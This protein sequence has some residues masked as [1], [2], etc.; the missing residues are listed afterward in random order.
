MS[1]FYVD[2][3]P[4]KNGEH[5]PESRSHVSNSEDGIP[6][7]NVQIEKFRKPLELPVRPNSLDLTNTKNA[8]YETVEFDKGNI[9]QSA[10]DIG[11]YDDNVDALRVRECPE[12]GRNLDGTKSNYRI[13]ENSPIAKHIQQER[14]SIAV[15]Y[16]RVY[17]DV[18]LK[19]KENSVMPRKGF[20]SLA[21]EKKVKGKSTS[22]VDETIGQFHG[23]DFDEDTEVFQRKPSQKILSSPTKDGKGFESISL[24]DE[25]ITTPLDEVE[26]RPYMNLGFHK[27][28]GKT[29]GGKRISADD[30]A[31]KMLMNLQS[32][33]KIGDELSA[34]RKGSEDTLAEKC[35]CDLYTD[36]NDDVSYVNVGKDRKL[37][38]SAGCDII[39]GNGKTRRT[40]EQRN[41]ED[42]SAYQ[43]ISIS[44]N[45][46]KAGQGLHQL[47]GSPP[48]SA[49]AR[50][51]PSVKQEFNDEHLYSNIGFGERIEN[52]SDSKREIPRPKP[53]PK[54]PERRK[55]SQVATKG[56][57]K[58]SDGNENISGYDEV[59]FSQTNS[60]TKNEA[61]HTN[62][63]ADFG[64]SESSYINV[65]SRG[66][67][68]DFDVGRVNGPQVAAS[69]SQKYMN[70]QEEF[71]PRRPRKKSSEAGLA[72]ADVVLIKGKEQTVDVFSD[73]DGPSPDI[74]ER[75]SP[76]GNVKEPSRSRCAYTEIDFM[77]SQGISEAVRERRVESFDD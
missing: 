57:R 32:E 36:E 15:N 45:V 33:K 39:Q 25:V 3:C 8:R 23:N 44:S 55:I 12:A 14:T 46:K 77:K 52:Q 42:A 17:T 56:A 63:L 61:G 58:V 50:E 30:T 70:V 27:K 41:A 73:R 13:N 76:R 9:C 22:D 26:G 20:M 68:D 7:S 1:H 53:R 24:R 31:I 59:R 6:G 49:K 34:R 29:G 5:L 19:D 75:N 64:I 43:N 62:I 18:T 4:V 16:E 11:S 71:Q 40:S 37:I 2:T 54:N 65:G 10:G 69:K 67:H 74:S 60:H 35:N 21:R 66:Y 28:K 72:Y 38:D 48:Y 51:N 47:V